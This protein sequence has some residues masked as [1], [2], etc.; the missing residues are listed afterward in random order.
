MS[1]T[2]NNSKI[3][4][5]LASG[6]KIPPLPEALVKVQALL[7]DPDATI[8]DVAGLIRQDG[9]LSGAVFR[10]VGSPVF[11]LRTKVDTVDRAVTL[12]GI[13][14]TL[15]ILRGIALRAALGGGAQSIALEALWQR[16]GQI[17]QA[18]MAVCKQLRPRGISPDQAYTLG[19]FHDCGLALVKR[20]PA[21]NDTLAQGL[22]SEIPVLDRSQN[23]DHALVGEMVARNWQLPDDIA[24]AIRNHHE[25]A[26]ENLA[27]IPTRLCA[28]LNLACHI[29]RQATGEDDQEWDQGW[30][31]AALNRLDL[32]ASDLA[33]LESEI[34]LEPSATA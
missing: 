28:L 17:A 13:P 11:G 18:T 9:A 31:D 6:I 7:Q 4:A 8:M 25:L 33:D 26:P 23:S 24:Q 2:R 20:I 14:P 19:M 3:Q 5:I 30:K 12:L 34:S 22:W 1:E 15:A 21:Y 29:H 27:D 16:S 10:V 32:T